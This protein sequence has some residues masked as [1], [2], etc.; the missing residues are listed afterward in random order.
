MNRD[1]MDLESILLRCPLF[2]AIPVK[3]QRKH[4]IEINKL[5]LTF[6][7]KAKELEHPKI[8]LKKNNVRELI[9]SK[10]KTYYKAIII[11]TAWNL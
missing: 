8:F 10:F 3:A 5:I 6:I 11:M 1:V 7:G 4:F 2:N 9:L